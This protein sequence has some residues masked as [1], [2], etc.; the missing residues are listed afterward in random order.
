MQVEVGEDASGPRSPP[1]CPKGP[2]GV[3]PSRKG[4]TSRCGADDPSVTIPEDTRMVRAHSG[5]RRQRPPAGILDPGMF[6][7]ETRRCMTRARAWHEHEDVQRE[8][9]PQ[10]DG[11]ASLASDVSEQVRWSRK[12]RS[13]EGGLGA[14]SPLHSIHV[15]P[16]CR[17]RKGVRPGAVFVASSGVDTTSGPMGFSSAGPPQGGLDP[18]SPQ[19]GPRDGGWSVSVPWACLLPP[20]LRWF[21]TRRVTPVL[22]GP[23]DAAPRKRVS[24]AGNGQESPSPRA[25]PRRFG[26]ARSDPHRSVR[27]PMAT[28]RTHAS[29]G[30][31]RG[32]GGCSL[33]LRSFGSGR[34]QAMKGRRM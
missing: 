10:M 3:S 20:V 16:A 12:G 27:T 6:G 15:D 1:V 30:P 24:P 4:G 5:A 18:G 33:P 21:P 25:Q 11:G 2:A 34:G 31:P 22:S 17:P 19:G 23:S 29:S 28:V 14:S 7:G 9:N 32:S 8:R 26:L 13:R